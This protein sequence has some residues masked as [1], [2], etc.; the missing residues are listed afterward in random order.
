MLQ[1]FESERRV[2]TGFVVSSACRQKVYYEI[3]WSRFS[4]KKKA[5]D[6]S[7]IPMHVPKQSKLL[8]Q[9]FMGSSSSLGMGVLVNN[10]YGE[11]PNNG[12]APAAA[13]APPLHTQ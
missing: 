6:D 10:W 5:L 13:A 3:D 2:E 12:E 8:G 11:L 9:V 7:Y 4:C 1:L